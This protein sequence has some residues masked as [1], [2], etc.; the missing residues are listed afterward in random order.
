MDCTSRRR[1]ECADA[2]RARGRSAADHASK[3]SQ[4]M[5]E[6][7]SE[8]VRCQTQLTNGAHHAALETTLDTGGDKAARE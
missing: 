8:A 4:R 2:A 3:K 7:T 6:T 1:T 5:V